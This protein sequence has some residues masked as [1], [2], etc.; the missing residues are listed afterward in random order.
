VLLDYVDGVIKVEWYAFFLDTLL[1]FGF[2]VY[3]FTMFFL[4]RA[5]VL[6]N[7]NIVYFFI[8]AHRHHQFIFCFCVCF[9]NFIFFHSSFRLCFFSN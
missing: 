4:L 7:Y 6:T 5:R 8:I 2:F 3:T 9:T 1:L